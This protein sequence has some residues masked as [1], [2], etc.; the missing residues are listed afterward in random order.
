MNLHLDT[1]VDGYGLCNRWFVFFRIKP[2]W[3]LVSIAGAGIVAT[4]LH[5]H[6]A[7]CQLFR[8][9]FLDSA[10]FSTRAQL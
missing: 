6:I 3:L 5:T 7:V 9:F 1:N 10:F 4:V 8:C 2:R